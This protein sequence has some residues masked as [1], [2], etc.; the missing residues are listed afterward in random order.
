MLRRS[1]AQ[2]AGGRQLRLVHHADDE[3]EALGAQ[4]LLHGPQRIGGAR[5]L[6]EQPRRGLEAERGKAMPVWGAELARERG[7]PAPQDTGS[8]RLRSFGALQAAHREAQGEAECGRPV[9][10]AGARS[11]CGWLGLQLVQGMRIEASA[12]TL[13]EIGVSERP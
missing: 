3:G 9:A 6:G 11:R 7:R 4:A 13:V 12:K 2:A 8:T 5:R 1:E 10:G